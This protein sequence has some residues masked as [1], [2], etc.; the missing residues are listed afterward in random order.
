MMRFGPK[1][2]CAERISLLAEKGFGGLLDVR[3]FQMMPLLIAVAM[4][5]ARLLAANF[6]MAW[7][8]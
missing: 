2:E 5:I 7:V 4:A 8:M 1:R 6:C 3:V